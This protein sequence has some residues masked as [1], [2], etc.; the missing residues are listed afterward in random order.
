MADKRLDIVGLGEPL[1]EFSQI[2]KAPPRFAMGFGGDT[3]N[4]V[5]AAARQGANTGYVTGIGDDQ[6]G[7]MFLDLWRHEGVDTTGVMIDPSAPTGIYFITHDDEGHHFSY[8][9]AGSA[10]SR[11]GPSRL[12][13][14]LLQETRLLH[15]SA[16]SQAISAEACDGVFE[17][18]DIVHSAGG[19]IAYDTN[20]RL[21]LWNLPRARA[22]I[23]ETVG[24]AD[25]ILPGLDDVRQIF[26]LDSPD[27]ITDRL[28]SLGAKIIGLTLGAEGAMLATPDRRQIIEGFPV[29]TVDATGAGDTFDGTFLAQYLQYGDP[30]AAG[31]FANAAAALSTQGYGAVD[32][33]PDQEAVTRFL[34]ARD[35]Q[36]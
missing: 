27:A 36:R 26:G 2:E 5:I 33:I 12:P 35:A 24:L 22:I 11:M 31:R 16:I 34:A 20:L 18:I 14:A 15:I 30:F 25:I 6:F 21:S 32:P 8:R 7:Q 10:A 4:C 28:L 3:S 9:R 1:L 23:T 29:E 19:L 13:K 17:A